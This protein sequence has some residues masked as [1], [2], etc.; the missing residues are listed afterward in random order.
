MGAENKLYGHSQ[1]SNVPASVEHFQEEELGI[2]TGF[3]GRW[4]SHHP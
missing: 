3:P 4:R 2:G 1:L